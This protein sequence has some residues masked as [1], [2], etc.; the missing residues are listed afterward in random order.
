MGLCERKGT[1]RN[2]THTLWCLLRQSAR[3]FTTQEHDFGW[4]L[5][6]HLTDHSWQKCFCLVAVSWNKSSK[7]GL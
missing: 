4:V 5:G 2:D 7:Q 3:Y 1:W 6:A